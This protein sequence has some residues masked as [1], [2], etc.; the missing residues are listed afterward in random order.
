MSITL[1]PD[2]QAQIQ[3]RIQRGQYPDAEALE[4]QEQA[5]FDTLWALVLADRQSGR[6]RELT[7]E[8][9]EE[10]AREADEAD[11]LGLPI[12]HEVQP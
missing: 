9:W 7:P 8:L 12:R 2:V 10:I 1:P 4:V 3:R 11:R 6:T 5:R